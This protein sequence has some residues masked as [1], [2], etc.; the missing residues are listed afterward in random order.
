MFFFFHVNHD[1]RKLQQ[2]KLSL[3]LSFVRLSSF[4]Y[5]KLLLYN[6]IELNSLDIEMR[7][8]NFGS[9]LFQ[10]TILFW[11]SEI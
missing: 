3:L 1:H 7:S 10:S 8:L 9:H 11:T 5:I 6:L 4:N 2:T